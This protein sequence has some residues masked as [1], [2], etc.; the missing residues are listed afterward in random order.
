[1][2]ADGAGVRKRKVGVGVE[3]SLKVLSLVLGEHS[4][5]LAMGQWPLL[6]VLEV[7]D[8]VRKRKAAVGET[9]TMTKTMTETAEAQAEVGAAV[10]SSCRWVLRVLAEAAAQAAVGEIM[11]TMTMAAVGVGEINL[12]G[13]RRNGVTVGVGV[14]AGACLTPGS[15]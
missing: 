2:A 10:T 7:G 1:M 5:T 9:M 15:S 4:Q 6:A 8:G 12:G 14:K 3:A 11:M 13:R